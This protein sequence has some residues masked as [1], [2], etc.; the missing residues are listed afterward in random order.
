MFLVVIKAFLNWGAFVGTSGCQKVFCLDGK[1]CISRMRITH[2]AN[3]LKRQTN[4][5][6]ITEDVFLNCTYHSRQKPQYKFYKLHI[7]GD[8]SCSILKTSF[9]H[10]APYLL[11]LCALWMGLESRVAV[12]NTWMSVI[13]FKL[14]FSFTGFFVRAPVVLD[15]NKFI[16]LNFIRT[17]VAEPTEGFKHNWSSYACSKFHLVGF[18]RDIR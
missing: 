3:T 6:A 13:V 17:F 7:L 14:Q 18:Q 12:S 8:A 15:R 10:G 9:G 4:K 1:V 16:K 11:Y 2:K 5:G